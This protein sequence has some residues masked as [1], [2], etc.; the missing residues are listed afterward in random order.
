MAGYNDEIFRISEDP[1]R[2]KDLFDMALDRLELIK[3]IP[4]EKA[5]K[6]IEE[7]CEL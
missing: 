6:I 7:Y 4:K 3:L 5:Y 1:E 2:A